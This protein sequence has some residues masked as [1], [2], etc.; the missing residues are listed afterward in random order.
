MT[1]FGS[2][3]STEILERVSDLCD[4][5]TLHERGP[6]GGRRRHQ[7]PPAAP[8]P[9]RDVDEALAHLRLRACCEPGA[10]VSIMRTAGEEGAS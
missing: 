1:A 10:S 3:I 7:L 4:T 2:L 6:R 8:L 5:R 9:L